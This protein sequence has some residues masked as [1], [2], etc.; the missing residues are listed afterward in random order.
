MPLDDGPDSS[1]DID[2]TLLGWLAARIHQI[3]WFTYYTE[4]VF[5]FMHNP[6]IM[7]TVCVCAMCMSYVSYSLYVLY[8]T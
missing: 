6:V 1:W 7:S 4:Q 8:N 2:T 5:T 3:Y